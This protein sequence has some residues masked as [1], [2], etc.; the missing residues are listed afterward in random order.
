MNYKSCWETVKYDRLKIGD[1]IY[2]TQHGETRIAIVL[3]PKY[4]KL[5]ALILTS[6]NTVRP[7]ALVENE[8]RLS[9]E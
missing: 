4:T 8:R 1:V 6:N 2:F 9:F 5:Q 7:L 3:N